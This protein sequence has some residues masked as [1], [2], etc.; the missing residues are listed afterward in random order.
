MSQ[1][2]YALIGNCQVSALLDTKAR[3]VWSCMPR[4]DSPAV[5]AALL[6]DDSNG[7][8]SILPDTDDYTTKQSYIRNTNVV[9][10]EF[11]YGAGD[12]FDIYDFAP[13]FA[14]R[15]RTYHAPRFMRIIRVVKGHPRV[16]MILDPKFDYGR[17]KPDIG[18]TG[19]GIIYRSE[20]ESLI[21]QTD[22]PLTYALKGQPF[23]INGDHYCVLSY[24]EPFLHP[25][26]FT[27]EEYYERTISYWHTWI[28][29]CNIP[30]EYQEAVIRSAL[31]LKLHIYEDTGAIIAATTTSIPETPTGGRTWDYR[32][33]WLRDAYFVIH[34]LYKLGQFEELRAFIQYIQNIAASSPSDELQ[35]LYGIGGERALVEREIPWLKGFKGMGPVRVGNAAYTHA[36]HDIY[37]ETVLA[38]TPLF[39]DQRLEKVDLGRAFET[40][41][42]LVNQSIA[43]FDLPDSGI[44]EFRSERQHYLFSKV[45]CWAAVDRGLKIAKKLG[46]AGAYEPWIQIHR[47]MREIIESK[48]WN[49]QLG[50]YTQNYGSQAPDA[51]NL[52]IGMVNFHAGKDEKFRR[53]VEAYER[54]LVSNGYTYRY[55]NRDDFGIPTNTFTICTF[56]MIDALAQIGRRDEAREI[57]ERVL[58][59]VNHVG[60]L[61]EDID[62]KTG[63][64]WGNFPQ[65]Y[66]HVGVINSA[67][68]LSKSWDEAF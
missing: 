4:F 60:L 12:R 22:M 54:L 30:F 59:R 35:P 8:W 43:V 48:G 20:G 52:L 39:F 37:G 28:Q 27:V 6:G 5:F 61:S 67:F 64:L 1:L 40:V 63:D 25:L 13:R 45:M 7:I 58:A 32:Y 29:H 41:L 47:R 33:C 65:A 55:I 23:E 26:K 56:W 62:P 66:S 36:Q 46:S 16:R 10:T 9:K 14:S 50:F 11:H 17:V 3:Y 44:W 15:D 68:R 2:D 19:D 38:I 57:F 42:R 18:Q 49:E 31:A 21:L 51:S 24:I 34:V 53:T